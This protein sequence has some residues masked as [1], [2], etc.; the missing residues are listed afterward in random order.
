VD[1]GAKKRDALGVTRLNDWRQ[2]WFADH[3][4][5]TRHESGQTKKKG[6]NKNKFILQFNPI[7]VSGAWPTES[8]CRK[9]IK[10]GRQV[11]TLRQRKPHAPHRQKKR[12]ELRM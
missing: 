4:Y 9:E 1:I 5:S 6:E 12:G 3:R 11:T 8:G 10:K 2:R 7:W